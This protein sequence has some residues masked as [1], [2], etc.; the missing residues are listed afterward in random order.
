MKKKLLIAGG[1]SLFIFIA[2]IESIL[3]FKIVNLKKEVW[4]ENQNIKD[5][6][7]YAW[8][9]YDNMEFAFNFLHPDDVYV[10]EI[11]DGLSN[12]KLFL[13]IYSHGE[14]C[15][16]A[17]E[18]MDPPDFRIVVKLNK[19]EYKTSEEAFYGENSRIDKKVNGHL[20]YFKLGGLD[21]Y[22]GEI[23]DN[24]PHIIA[25]STKINS[26]NSVILKNDY[27]IIISIGSYNVV[28][29]GGE[30]SGQKPLADAILG[31]LEFNTLYF[32]K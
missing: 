29:Y 11:E 17:R 23:L 5:L 12:A 16:I 28:R 21:A 13:G 25:L 2:A 32:W 6:I 8:K 30:I 9:R 10:C 14:T 19:D 31:T 27:L 1:I 18:S 22:G 20:G 3:Y 7:A 4:E 26:Y 24:N 15:K